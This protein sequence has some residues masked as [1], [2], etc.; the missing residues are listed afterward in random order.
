MESFV[1]GLAAQIQGNHT[2]IVLLLAFLGGI[3]SSL[4]PC[5]LGLLPI[6]IAYIGGYSKESPL[7]LFAQLLSFSIGMSIVLS[8]IGVIC[9]LTGKAFAGMSSPIWILLLSSLI[10]IFGLDLLGVIQ[11]NFPTLIKKMPQNNTNSIFVFPV[12]IGM[13]FAIAATPCSSPILASIMALASL[14]ANVAISIALFFLFALGQCIIIIIAGLFAS[15]LK[16]MKAFAGFTGI[17]MKL[18][19]LLFVLISLYIYYVIFKEF[20]V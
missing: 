15:A 20:F 7:R 12:L 17:L 9:A 19:G 3:A 10:M 11:L 6:V 2:T 8:I 5:S 18:C 13:V 16:N 14:S 4:S 1:Q